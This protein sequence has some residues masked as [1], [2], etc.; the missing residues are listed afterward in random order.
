MLIFIFVIFTFF[1]FFSPL[2]TDSLRGGEGR[3]GGGQNLGLRV[4]KREGGV[5]EGEKGREGKG[6]KSGRNRDLRV[7]VAGSLYP[8]MPP[9]CPSPSP[10]PIQSEMAKMSN[11]GIK[12][13][14]N[15]QFAVQ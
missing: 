14:R 11:P 7:R 15:G 13:S 9:P 6:K 1:L 10:S 8:S 5:R 2:V 3:D 4:E 12:V